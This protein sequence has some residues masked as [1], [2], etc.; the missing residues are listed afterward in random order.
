MIIPLVVIDELD[1]KKYARRE[2]FQQRA[3]DLLSLTSIFRLSVALA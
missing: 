2:E 1:N 3:R